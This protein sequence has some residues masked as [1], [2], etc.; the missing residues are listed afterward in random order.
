MRLDLNKAGRRGQS[1][2][3]ETESQQAKKDYI[4]FRKC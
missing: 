4:I 3:N 2:L 1:R